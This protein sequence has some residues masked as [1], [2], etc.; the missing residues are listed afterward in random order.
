MKLSITLPGKDVAY[1]DRHIAD[2]DEPSRSAVIR[3]A[4]ERLRHEE[5]SAAYAEICKEWGTEDD[6]LWETTVGDGLE[7]EEWPNAPQT[8]P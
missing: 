4:I 3:K 6:L 2:H 5:L 1:I 8:I 7:D